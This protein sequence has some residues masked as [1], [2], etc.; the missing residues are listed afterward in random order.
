MHDSLWWL[1]SL[2]VVPGLLALTLLM[3]F[4]ET[5]LAQRLIAH[6]VA[7]ALQTAPTAD[8]LEAAVSRSV[9]PLLPSRP[10]ARQAA[11]RR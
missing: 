5:H 9:A 7:Q 4:M 1:L 2:A 8:D 3:D 11:S 10:D 6:D